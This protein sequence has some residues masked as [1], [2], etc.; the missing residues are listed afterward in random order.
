MAQATIAPG[1]VY[2]FSH[3]VG[4][5]AQFGS[6]FNLPVDIA[7]GEGN[8]VYILNRGSE[9]NFFGMRVSKMSIGAPREE[10]FILDIGKYGEGPGQWLAAAGVAVDS[11]ENLYV[12]DDWLHRVTV[13]DK[14]GILLDTWSRPQGSARGELD[15]PFGMAFDADDNLYLVDSR[16]HRVQKFTKDGQFLSTFGSFGSGDGQFNLPWGINIDQQGNL[17]VADWKNHRIQQFSPEGRLLLKF[18]SYGHEPGE[19]HHPTHMTVDD[20]GDIYVCDW[21]NHRLQI[22]DAEGQV[23]TSLLGDAQR[24]SKWAE[25]TINAN[26]DA[27]KARRRVKHPELEWRF[28]HPVTVAYHRASRRIMVVDTMRSRIQVYIKERDYQDPQYNL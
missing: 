28:C 5:A 18:G 19:L 4:R 9:T 16:N 21:A 23:I 26:P 11:Q 25:M 10:E 20:D 15:G 24:L 7:L 13:F 12:S 1:R 8:V 17:Y 2:N 6:G 3:A 14:D 27:I 22:F